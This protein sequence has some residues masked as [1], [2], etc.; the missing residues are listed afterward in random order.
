ML[1]VLNLA[2]RVRLK[3]KS[4]NQIHC[5]VPTIC[6]V[7]LDLYQS[8]G[9]LC[10]QKKENAYNN[11]LKLHKPFIGEKRANIYCCSLCIF[12]SILTSGRKDNVTQL[13]SV[14]YLTN[15]FAQKSVLQ[16]AFRSVMLHIIYP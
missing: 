2:L 15:H 9:S 6:D 8:R 12:V 11:H 5:I 7:K 14:R 13:L 10:K 1:I 3:A 16:F 4:G